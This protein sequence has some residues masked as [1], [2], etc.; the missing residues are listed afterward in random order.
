MSLVEFYCADKELYVVGGFDGEEKFKSVCSLNLDTLKWQALPP[1]HKERCYISI[2]EAE[3]KLY[4]MGGFDGTGD[5]LRLS[6]CEVF[7]PKTNQWTEIS[8]MNETRSDA[9]AVSH[10]RNIYIAGGESFWSSNCNYCA[11]SR[12]ILSL[13]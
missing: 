8:T 3:G 7:D 10:G 9:A 13:L 5:N 4:A 12:K 2:V 11:L 6:T 1:M